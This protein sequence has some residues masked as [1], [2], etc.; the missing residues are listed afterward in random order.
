MDDLAAQISNK[1]EDSSQQA[2]IPAPATHNIDTNHD[3]DAKK[4]AHA[5]SVD[6]ESDQSTLQLG[7]PPGNEDLNPMTSGEQADAKKFFHK[8]FFYILIGVLVIS[9]I[10]GTVLGVTLSPRA[11]QPPGTTATCSNNAGPNAGSNP[12]AARL[13]YSIDPITHCLDILFQF[14]I[15][16]EPGIGLDLDRS[17]FF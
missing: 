13:H 7:N 16:S 4:L 3:V 10:V 6:L 14:F 2:R 1:S 5:P 17:V 8:P 15:S 9:V 12:F 11:S